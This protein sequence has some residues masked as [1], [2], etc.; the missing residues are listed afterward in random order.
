MKAIFLGVV[1]RS[2]S[3]TFLV[4]LSLILAA[5]AVTFSVA[6][7]M[8]DRNTIAWINEQTERLIPISQR[9]ASSA[10]W[11][12]LADAL[13]DKNDAL[14]KNYSRELARMMHSWVGKEGSIFAV[15]LYSGK[16][17]EFYPS[18]PELTELETTAWEREA[19]STHKTT[20]T[21]APYTDEIGTYLAAYTPVMRDGHVIG[22]IAASVDSATLSD[23][24]GIVRQ[25]FFFSLLLALVVS[26][27]SSLTL[28]YWFVDPIE[29]FRAVEE[30]AIGL[31][32][33]SGIPDFWDSLTPKQKVLAELARQ[34][35]T[36]QEIAVKESISVD[37]V[38]THFKN[39]RE[40]TGLKK[41]Q[42]A[43][44]A[45]ARRSLPEPS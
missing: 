26:V 30:T 42:L 18:D 11:S 40:K 41:S 35:L 14:R 39:I 12:R 17:Y 4:F 2:T 13:D 10:D 33:P 36:N 22:L 24:H 38:K 19:Y 31:A 16:S 21:P 44:Q 43:V 37:T 32:Q 23:F 6:W 29:V 45:E 8:L 7:L 15:I 9:A 1:R 27:V 28:A 20:F 5:E 25:T 34:G 3:R